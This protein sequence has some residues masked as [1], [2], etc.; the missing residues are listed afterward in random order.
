MDREAYVLNINSLLP[1]GEWTLGSDVGYGE[2]KAS[3]L[4]PVDQE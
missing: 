3:R 2:P 1:A 4:S